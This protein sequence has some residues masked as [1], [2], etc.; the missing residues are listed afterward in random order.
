MERTSSPNW[1][2]LGRIALLVDQRR[3]VLPLR[4][5]NTREFEELWRRNVHVRLGPFHSNW[6]EPFLFSRPER[7]NGKLPI[8]IALINV[9]SFRRILSTRSLVTYLPQFSCYLKLHVKAISLRTIFRFSI[10]FYVL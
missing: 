9:W 3:S 2:V 5:A 1:S 6:P 8:Y 10:S 7:T 4:S